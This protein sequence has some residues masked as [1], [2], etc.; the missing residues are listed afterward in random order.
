[1][2]YRS[3][4]LQRNWPA[5]A[6]LWVLGS[7][8]MSLVVLAALVGIFE[9]EPP[10]AVAWTLLF[11]A[12]LGFLLALIG[13]SFIRARGETAMAIVALVLAL[14]LTSLVSPFFL[15]FGGLGVD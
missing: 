2:T 9:L 6:A 5:L 14:S 12:A 11:I 13:I 15:F 3:V 10:E 8:W 4:L 7:V 1:M